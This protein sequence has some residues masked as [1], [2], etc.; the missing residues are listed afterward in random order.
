MLPV[1]KYYEMNTNIC[2][3]VGGVI[4]QLM[5][6]SMGAVGGSGWQWTWVTK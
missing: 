2:G 4:L 3:S 1:L 5:A 6:F